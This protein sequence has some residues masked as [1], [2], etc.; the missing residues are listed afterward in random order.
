MIIKFYLLKLVRK[1]VNSYRLL[2]FVNIFMLFVSIGLFL[3]TFSPKV[4]SMLHYFD[5]YSIFD[6]IYHFITGYHCYVT[7]SCVSF[8]T[9][10]G[11]ESMDII[12]SPE[13][14]ALYNLAE[15]NA[16]A[17][18]EEYRISQVFLEEVLRYY[19]AYL[20]QDTPGLT[21]E[22]LDRLSCIKSDPRMPLFEDAFKQGMARGFSEDLIF[23]FLQQQ[24][25]LAALEQFQVYYAACDAPVMRELAF[26]MD[27]Y[28]NVYRMGPN[29]VKVFNFD[30][31]FIHW[32]PSGALPFD[33]FLLFD[34]V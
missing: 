27:Y 26:F 20:W 5:F 30:A 6:I 3:V 15:A 16:K 13:L 24:L 10:R 23:A 4:I 21:L 8:V 33:Y 11:S 32:V 14:L 7:R 19:L 28:V 18:L 34:I 9:S 31:L 2:I 1:I 25:T 12:M 29:T 17:L 22:M